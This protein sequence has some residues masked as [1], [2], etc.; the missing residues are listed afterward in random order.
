MSDIQIVNCHVHLFTDCHVPTLFPH[1]SLWPVKRFPWLIGLIAAAV[2]LPLGDAFADKVMRLKQ[3]QQEVDIPHQSEVF[4]NLCRRY[5]DNTRFVVLPM[6]LSRIGHRPPPVGLR[7]Q[8]DE[9]AKLAA[10]ND[11]VIPFAK[12]DPRADPQARELWRAIDELGFRGI[13]I[14][15]RL[16]YPPTHDTLMRHVYGKAEATGR[17][18]MTHCARGGVQGR[19][20]PDHRADAYTDPMSYLP[21][22]KEFPKLRICLAHFGGARDWEAYVNP[23]RPSPYRPEDTRNWLRMIRELITSRQY[24][25]LWTDISYTLFNFENHAPFLRMFLLEDRR[26]DAETAAGKEWLRRRV[27]FGSDYYMT[28]QERLS[29]KAVCIRL[30]NTLGEDLFR[31]IAEENPRVWL[32]EKAEPPLP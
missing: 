4:E 15:P 10:E 1:W 20:L 26:D 2:R 6:D 8:H 31:Q 7:E 28:K 14:Y 24:P 18:V 11:A 23:K 25:G 5:P 16:G 32:G 29:E 3:F 21:I 27:L 30:R 19:D 9:L 13:K 22:L 12:I 17:P